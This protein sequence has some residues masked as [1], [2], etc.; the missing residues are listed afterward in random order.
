MILIDNFVEE[1]NVDLSFFM[2]RSVEE[3]LENSPRW[4]RAMKAYITW[5]H[6]GAY[7]FQRSDDSVGHHH[8]PALYWEAV[9]TI[10]NKE[11]VYILER[12]IKHSSGRKY[13][14]GHWNP[15]E[16]S[17]VLSIGRLFNDNVDIHFP[18]S[19]KNV[20]KK[21]RHSLFIDNDKDI[22]RMIRIISFMLAVK[23]KIVLYELSGDEEHFD[24][25]LMWL[26]ASKGTLNLKSYQL[27]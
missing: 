17:D 23:R 7:V 10:F 26:A 19:I 18:R 11:F 6:L 20:P 14:S 3:V 8:P 25:F 2:P 13:S 15:L 22:I 16:K 27:W 5:F 1:R 9:S 24:S 12:L 21:Y 4:T